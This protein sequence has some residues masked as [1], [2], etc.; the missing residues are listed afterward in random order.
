M[1]LENEVQMHKN[2]DNLAYELANINKI[3][4][5]AD[6]KAKDKMKDHAKL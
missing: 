6:K 3:K 5:L 2:M 1:R 4:A